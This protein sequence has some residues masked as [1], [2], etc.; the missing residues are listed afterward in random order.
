MSVAVYVPNDSDI[1]N[2]VDWA[3]EFARASHS[4]LQVVL[5][6]KSKSKTRWNEVGVPDEDAGS[7][8]RAIFEALADQD[9]AEIVLR[10][11][12]ADGEECSNHD[13][14][15][16]SVYELQSPDPEASFVE[17]LP[18]LDVDLLLIPT[19]VPV[20]S[21]KVGDRGANETIF[22][23]V[24]CQ[25]VCIG[26]SYAADAT[27]KAPKL[28]LVCENDQDTDDD[29]ALAKTAQL[30]R[31]MGAEVTLLYVRRPDDLVARH[32]A[33]RR[34][35][36]LARG[37]GAKKIVPEKAAALAESFVDGINQ[38]DLRKFDLILAG[39]RSKKTIRRLVD[40]LN[41]EA[42]GR[43]VALAILKQGTPLADRVWEKLKLTVRGFVPQIDR[44]HRVNLVDRL[45][46]SSKFDFDFIAL[47]SLSTLIAALGLVRDSGAVVIGAML[48]APLMT[49]IVA[50]GLA[51]VQG[52]ERLLQDGV[53]SVI[54]G[55]AVAVLI[56]FV[57]GVCTVAGFSISPQ[58]YARGGPNMLD[59]IVAL[60]SGVAAAYAMGRP[61]LVSA[62][63]G[64]AIAAALVPPIATAGLALPMGDLTLAGGAALLFFTNVVAIVL[65]TAITFWS[66]GIS[67]YVDSKSEL[68]NVRVWPRYWF[69]A[70]VIISCLL[71]AQMTYWSGN[72]T[73]SPTEPASGNT[74]AI[75]GELDS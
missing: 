54:F 31:S 27:D 68:Q 3:I 74:E 32:V 60:A 66:V 64:V 63:P 25:V 45:N 42:D 43:Q 37:F 19:F 41:R 51:L 33:D 40:N 50:I 75:I 5:P 52:N 1:L 12:I 65:G 36:K 20:R 49:P 29:F 22:D 57:V 21:S 9:S 10:A 8:H 55:F 23:S 24:P 44:E 67:T 62:L 48:V 71:A 14:T 59:L 61:H 28:L 35:K 53:R 16:V 70:F 7:R 34:L 18:E 39:T 46:S 11:K 6:S 13:R 2:L 58:M 30:T 26:G 72:E 73:G 69:L 15:V 38:L 4:P 56:G 47:V 17:K